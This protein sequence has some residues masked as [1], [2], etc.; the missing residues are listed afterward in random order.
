[1]F[2]IMQYETPRT[3]ACL[4]GLK[5]PDATLNTPPCLSVSLHVVTATNANSDEFQPA[6]TCTRIRLVNLIY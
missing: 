2:E 1:M 5:V 4:L 3:T 6:S